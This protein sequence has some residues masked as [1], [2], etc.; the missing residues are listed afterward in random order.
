[1]R[2]GEPPASEVG[3]WRGSTKR[4]ELLIMSYFAVVKREMIDMVPKAITLTLVNHAK[5]NLQRELLEHLYK[6]EVL[7]ELLKESPDIVARYV[8]YSS[9]AG[10]A[11]GRWQVDG[12]PRDQTLLRA[13][14]TRLGTRRPIGGPTA[15]LTMQTARVRQ[16]GRRTQ[17][18]R[19]HRGCRL[20]R[21][22]LSGEC[23]DRE[24]RASQ[25]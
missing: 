8:S 14:E 13:T 1:M 20:S 6:P 12:K 10:V 17:L 24:C 9:C 16:D 15:E 3:A 2:G 21:A 4:T 18:G 25:K 19:G 11:G 22:V 23:R 7:E 5:E